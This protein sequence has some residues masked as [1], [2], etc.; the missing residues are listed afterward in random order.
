MKTLLYNLLVL[1][2]GLGV[3]TVT[4]AQ[5]T[6]KANSETQKTTI[7]VRVAEEKNGKT[8]VTERTYRY[9]GLSDDEKELKV[10]GIIDSL[11]TKSSADVT[12]RRLSVTV[13]EGDGTSFG[14]DDNQTMDFADGQ[15]YIYKHDSRATADRM[16]RMEKDMKE[17]TEK[18]NREF[19]TFGQQFK[20][21]FNHAW[22]GSV[23]DPASHKPASVRGLEAY[24]NNPDKNELNVRF[25]APN[26]GDINIIITD[27]RGKQ[28]AKKEVKDFSGDFVG[29]I[30]IG[31]NA[32]GTYFITV[33]QNE[34]G[35]VKRI[36][37]D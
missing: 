36:V 12:N 17:R 9:N 29:Q 30:D 1:C 19:K 13:E 28:I 14:N 15:V 4:Q 10:K 3:A 35:A 26:K 37:V 6:P 33:T 22:K 8:D 34:D 7:R 32:K 11:Q 27:P 23:F 20:Y 18:M 16:K 2:A 31:K 5:D 21:D 24:P 25:Y